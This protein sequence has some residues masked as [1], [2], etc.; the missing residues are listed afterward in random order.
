MGEIHPGCCRCHLCVITSVLTGRRQRGFDYRK[1]GDDMMEASG[2]E[3][4]S[5][6]ESRQPP[7]VRKGKDNPLKPLAGTGLADSLSVSETECRL[8]VSRNVRD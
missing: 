1:E 8:L 6:G 5:A 2:K 4:S 7:E 3:S